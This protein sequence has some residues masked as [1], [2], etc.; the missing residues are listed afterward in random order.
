M[1]IVRIIAGIKRLLHIFK[2]LFSSEPAVLQAEPE[3][4]SELGK[5]Y[6][7]KVKQVRYNEAIVSLPPG[8][9]GRLHKSEISHEFVENANRLLWLGQQIKVK[10]IKIDDDGRPM[11]SIKALDS[12]EREQPELGKVY[13]VRVITVLNYRAFVSLLPGIKGLLNKSEISHEPVENA[14]DHLQSGQLIK[15]KVIKIRDD[16]KAHLSMKALDDSKPS[17]A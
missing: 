4:Q 8:I 2:A 12:S 1:A 11:L 17:P 5:I 16:G 6:D 10:V 13:E 3:E 15:V 7:G 14:N 9:T